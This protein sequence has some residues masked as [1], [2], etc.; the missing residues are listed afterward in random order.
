MIL[1]KL[2]ITESAAES[3]AFVAATARIFLDL[4]LDGGAIHNGVWIAALL[5]ALP[6]IPYLLCLAVVQPDRRTAATLYIAW[7]SV[8]VMD[9]AHVLLLVVRVSGYLSLERVPS[10]LL[11]LPLAL[12]VLWC[13]W[14]N[15]DAVGYAAALWTRV[16]PAWLLLVILLQIRHCNARWL[17]PLLGNGWNDILRDGLR[18][19]GWCVPATAILC[20]VERKSDGSGTRPHPA[21]IARAFALASLLLALRLMMAPTGRHEL[22]WLARLDALLTNGRA[23]LYLQLPMILIFFTSGLHLLACEAFAASALL[24][25]LWPLD[26]RVCAALV[27]L[28]CTCLSLSGVTPFAMERIAPWIYIV[29]AALIAL[30]VLVQYALRGG[31]RT[32]GG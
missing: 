11:A 22:L 28:A 5:G 17:F 23:P 13:L 14:R 6:A 3:A 26:G 27:M 9:A 16:F 25:R 4:A 12:S 32:C 31:E 1:L 15:G 24:Q 21:R 10:P 20:I 19:A 8:T 30:T 7:L 29:G 18:A 2:S